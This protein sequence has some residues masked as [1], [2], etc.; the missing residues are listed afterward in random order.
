MELREKLSNIQQKIKAPK[1]LY[2]SFGKYNY[3]N[4][5]SILEA[6]KPYEKEYNVMLTLTDT[7]IQVYERIYIQ[8]TA[9]L[10]DCQ[11][12]AHIEVSAFAREPDEKKGMDDSQ[13]T[14]TASSYARKYALNGLLLLD[15]TKDADTDEYHNQT[16]KDS[17]ANKAAKQNKPSAIAQAMFNAQ[18]V[19]QSMINAL[20]LELSR[21]GIGLNGVL[22]KYKLPDIHNMTVAQFKEAMD[23]LK[24]KPD[25]PK[26]NKAHAENT[27][28][29]DVPDEGLPW[30]T[31]E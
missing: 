31:P 29:P 4:A 12:D 21:T 18:V 25:K 26:L 27:I 20:F 5:E 19:D 28:P 13:V 22:A 7:I 3:R 16:N 6:F 23:T 1:N 30:N 24:K 11:S 17:A 10:Y 2:N 15:D 8:A 14:G 9:T